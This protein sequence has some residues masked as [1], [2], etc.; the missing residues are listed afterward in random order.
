MLYFAVLI[1]SLSLPGVFTFASF[2]SYRHYSP[3]HRGVLMGISA[4]FG[5]A[6][7]V[8]VMVIGG[9]LF[10]SWDRNGPFNLYFILILITLGMV[11][12]YKLT[13]KIK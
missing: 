1:A 6:G 2:L 9:Y 7:V 3:S 8:T 11:L 4:I 12:Y 10:D 5:V 13:K